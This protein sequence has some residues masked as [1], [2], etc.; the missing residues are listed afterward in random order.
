MLIR[1]PPPGWT[2]HRF[3]MDTG[4]CSYGK[5]AGHARIALP[6][7]HRTT[8]PRRLL[9]CDSQHLVHMSTSLGTR[10]RREY[11][12]HVTLLVHTRSL[13]R[14]MASTLRLSQTGPWAWAHGVLLLRLL[15]PLRSCRQTS[16][17]TMPCIQ[18]SH[19]ESCRHGTD[20]KNLYLCKSQ[21]RARCS[22][23]RTRAQAMFSR[24]DAHDERCRRAPTRRRP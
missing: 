13:A 14:K 11:P 21:G 4:E 15:G 8:I 12:A 22:S 16:S 7:K 18:T 19:V 20:G 9:R 6:A 17:A 24:P 1:R 2:P 10:V 3:P 23:S 5:H